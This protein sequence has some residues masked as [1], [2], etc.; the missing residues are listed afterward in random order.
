MFR[1]FVL[2]CLLQVSFYGATAAQTL[3]VVKQNGVVKCGI[4]S[5]DPGFAMMDKTGDWTGFNV[6]ICRAIAAAVFDDPTAIEIVPLHL[7]KSAFYALESGELDVLPFSPFSPNIPMPEDVKF[8]APTFFDG[9]GFM[10]REASGI[11][12]PMELDG[13]Y[14]CTEADPSAAAYALNYSRQNKVTFKFVHFD[15]ISEAAS[16]YDA[17]RC[18]AYIS[19]KTALA[20]ERRKMA[21]PWAHEILSEVISKESFGPVVRGNDPEWQT[22]VALVIHAMITAEE[23]GITSDNVKGMRKFSKNPQV[24]KLLRKA[25]TGAE[26]ALSQDWAFNVIQTV[27]NYG[28][29]YSRNLGAK[30]GVKLER[31]LNDLWSNGGIMYAPD[32]Q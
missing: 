18:D 26:I 28:E 9:K 13:A 6:D 10:I 24:L 2:G 4:E 27:G 25:A 8:V 31:G 29:I 1:I 30:S 15:T 14:L 23:F 7:K 17:G 16:A 21:E 20:A 3:K 22:V 5:F 32:Y 11:K 12:S 19:N